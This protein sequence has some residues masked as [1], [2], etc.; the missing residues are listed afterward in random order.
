MDHTRTPLERAALVVAAVA[1]SLATLSAFVVAPSHFTH[2][3]VIVQSA[4]A[5][6]VVDVKYL[7]YQPVTRIN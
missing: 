3:A 4:P 2:E 5:Y 6:A 1:L 7:S